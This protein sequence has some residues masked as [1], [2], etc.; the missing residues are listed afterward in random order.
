M[1]EV[2]GAIC[3][4]R[5]A[6]EA[7]QGACRDERAALGEGIGVCAVT[8]TRSL[9]G[10]SRLTSTKAPWS[11]E[12]APCTR[13]D[14]P[15]TSTY[16]DCP[17][18]MPPLWTRE[19]PVTA[20]GPRFTRTSAPRG[21]WSAPTTRRGRHWGPRTPPPGETP[22]SSAQSKRSRSF[23]MKDLRCGC[24]SSPSSFASSS[25][26]VRCFSVSCVGTSMVTSTR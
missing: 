26:S 19:A 7:D 14:P 9:P 25:S 12:K 22:P 8:G 21:S 13:S 20:N 3:V 15:I 11:R 17:S 2:R 1:R 6:T 23:S 24:T 5:S 10:N 16:R 4:N 18:T